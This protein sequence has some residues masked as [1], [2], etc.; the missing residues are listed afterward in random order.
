[1]SLQKWA[2]MNA[3]KKVKFWK[4]G[5]KVLIFKKLYNLANTY[6]LQLDLRTWYWPI[7]EV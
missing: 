2:E 5:S 3:I 6:E 4:Q 1:M 7:R